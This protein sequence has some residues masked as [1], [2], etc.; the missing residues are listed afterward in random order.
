MN[1]FEWFDPPGWIY[2]IS[3]VASAF[4]FSACMRARLR[5]MQRVGVYALLSGALILYMEL[6][7]GVPQVLFLPCMSFVVLLMFCLLWSCCDI[8]PLDAGYYTTQAFIT[9]EF[10]ASMECQLFFF[11]VGERKELSGSMDRCMFLIVVYLVLYTLIYFWLKKLFRQEMNLRITRK[12][13]TCA[14]IIAC[15]VYGLSNLSYVAA[16]TPFSG[17]LPGEIF[18]IHTLVDVGGIA[19]LWAYHMMLSEMHLQMEMDNMENILN[20]QY[21]NYQLS[22]KS[23]D[24][25]NQKYHDLKHQIAILKS[26]F[27]TKE[28]LEYLDRMQNEI[29][30]YEAQNKTGN[31]ILDTVLTSKS[32]YCQ[33]KGIKLTCVADG[34]ALE[35]MDVMDISALFGNALDNAI[36]SVDK[37]QNP[38]KRLIHV[39]VAK[40]KGFLRIR[41]EN[42]YEGELVFENGLP[43]TTKKEKNYH[44]YGIKSI[45][46]TARKYNGSV[47]I[48]AKD[49]WFE[50]RIL[51]PV[52]EK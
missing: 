25:V 6:T 29:E 28:G 11:W 4:V 14:V 45:Q 24:M 18:N 30:I 21:A 40:Q 10:A 3:Y 15:V 41:V 50:L 27:G 34:T 19:I 46:S 33:G 52:Q 31:K 9:G 12:E 16:N 44:G 23:V 26:E 32:I 36:E 47:T 38:E 2:A 48:D 7:D 5:G 51:I 42:C 39:T 22:E 43:K 35:F 49:G 17:Q 37:I 20:M 1:Y 13:L 8:S